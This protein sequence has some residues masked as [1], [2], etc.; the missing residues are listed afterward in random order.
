[1]AIL[2]LIVLVVLIIEFLVPISENNHR[3]LA[4]IELSVV[5][6]FAI[7]YLYRL[8]KA[9]NKI[10][11]VRGHILDLLAILPVDSFLRISKLS[12]LAEV[13]FTEMSR[14]F[15]VSRIARI[16]LFGKKFFGGFFALIKTNGLHYMIFFTTA[17]VFSGAAGILHFEK[18]YG[19]ITNFGDA[20]WWS[21]VTT[22][23]V[24]YGDFAPVSA[25]GRI[26][27][28]FMM[29]AGI[30]FL[31]MVTGSI[32][33][34]FLTKVP[35]ESVH[36]SV[37]DEEI[38]YIKHKLDELDNLSREDVLTLNRVIVGLW[39]DKHAVHG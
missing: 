32:A 36:K 24:G 3:T 35:S 10:K 37:V 1:M 17:I 12:I 2:A 29:I 26:L 8:K 15:K 18:P 34:F 9:K 5:M 38:D 28:A 4:Q 16:I 25:G 23:T 33:T 13:H 7:D 14:V 20:L 21:M 39:E 11:F 30:G 19:T 31:G 6:V 27:A 22:A